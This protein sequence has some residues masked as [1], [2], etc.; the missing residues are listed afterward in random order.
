MSTTTE[1]HFQ[2]FVATE[3]K[4]LL[5]VAYLLTGDRGHAEDLMQTALYKAYVHWW[6]VMRYERPEAY[7]RKVMLNERRR[8][9]RRRKPGESLTAEPPDRGTPDGTPA[10]DERDEMWTQLQK[11]PPRTRAVVVLRY[12]EDRSEAETASILDCSVGTVK[13]LASVGLSRLRVQLDTKQEG[14]A[15]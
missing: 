5:H 4:A 13:K 2:A 15:R 3:A 11:L 6:R 14:L 9:W 10:V 8:I 12:W 7:V 1:Q